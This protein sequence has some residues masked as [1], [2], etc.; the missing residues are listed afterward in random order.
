MAC[1]QSQNSEQAH[2]ID[3]AGDGLMMKRR[4]NLPAG[5]ECLLVL[6][7]GA[8]S[9]LGWAPTGWWPVLSLCLAIFYSR[10]VML[11]NV[12]RAAWLGWLYGTAQQCFGQIWVLSAA[13]HIG[14]DV[15]V[16]ILSVAVFA[17]L[18]GVAV[19]WASALCVA[20]PL[21]KGGLLS[22][23]WMRGIVFSGSLVCAEWLRGY[24]TAGSS[25]LDVGYA[26]VD[27][28][29]RAYLPLLGVT[30]TGFI[31][32]LISTLAGWA[33]QSRHVR[34]ALLAT[35]ISGVLVLI[36]WQL[37]HHAWTVFSHSPISFRLLQPNLSSVDK[38]DASLAIAHLRDLTQQIEK[39][40]AMIIATPET[41]VPVFLTE[42]PPEYPE[43]WTQFAARSAS[44]LLIGMPVMGQ[45]S[46]A[47]NAMVH[48][49]P[50]TPDVSVHLK[51]RLMP[52]GEFTPPGMSWLTRSWTL[53]LKDLTPG[54]PSDD[55]VRVGPSSVGMMICHEAR[56]GSEG[57]RWAALAQ[58]IVNPVNLGWFDSA[59]ALA[60]HLQIVRSR[61]AEIGRPILLVSNHGGSAYIAA[62]GMVIEQL[63]L[64]VK[65][66]L[67]GQ[68]Q[69]TEGMTPYAQFGEALLAGL[70][71][72]MSVVASAFN[73]ISRYP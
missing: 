23:P 58:V 67:L 9:S 25:Q 56:Y 20:V 68:V 29:L 30:G 59:T 37:D 3:A 18:S 44:H 66:E 73:L 43:R 26:W 61:A 63:P 71:L 48:V 46:K 2:S 69:P 53:P 65:G 21:A 34:S 5:M 14:M 41:A 49:A 52:F 40:G 10:L 45:H 17:S 70:I 60:Q 42:I 32:A 57:R 4:E 8:C 6:G 64:H 38:F 13:Q 72:S 39:R 36:G 16:S 11:H 51:T 15:G 54:V 31:A 24:L 55:A 7:L 12:R 62:N 47:H 33:M 28:W 50:D 35:G 19:L 22:G 27:T 1:G